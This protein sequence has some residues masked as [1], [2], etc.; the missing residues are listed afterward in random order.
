M[1]YRKICIVGPGAIGGMM[2]VLMKEAGAEVTAL[3]RP[4][5]AAAIQAQGL[6]L[7]LADRTL[8]ARMSAS[9]DPRDLGLQD[10]VVVTLKGTALLSMADKIA[11][12]CRPDT[13]VVFVMNGVPWWFFDGF[14]GGLA[15]KRLK[16]VDPD[17]V[18]GRTFPADRTVWGVIN[19]SV[20]ERTDGVI[21]HT[22][23]NHLILGRPD[24]G[25]AGMTEIADVFRRAGY[26]T[27][28]DA[29]IR[30]K[31]WAKLVVNVSGN[32]V[33]ALTGALLHEMYDDPLV[34]ECAAAIA[35]EARTLGAHLGLGEGAN[36]IEAMKGSPV[37]SS[38]LQDLE[39]GRAL[40]LG[41]IVE[42]VVEIG[43]AAGVPLPQTRAILGLTRLRAATAGLA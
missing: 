26:E 16:A 27:P 7:A 30:R 15:G 35:N 31:I 4:A 12:L 33:S 25:A 3:A 42:A 39:R 13:P 36:P 2:A 43:E 37:R 8:T 11:A 34:R 28:V 41:S 20:I 24:G 6:T 38:M 21:E 10:L 18:L 9:S 40:E 5:K 23:N 14:G 1:T 29:D 19:C 17:G 22:R 32:P